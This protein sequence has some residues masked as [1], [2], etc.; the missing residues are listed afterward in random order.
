MC[1]TVLNDKFTSAE[2]CIAKNKPVT[3]WIVKH[4]PNKDPKFH[5]V[6]ILDGVGKSINAPLIILIR[7]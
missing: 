5:I 2:K 1:A 4:S 6:E 3:I 7:G